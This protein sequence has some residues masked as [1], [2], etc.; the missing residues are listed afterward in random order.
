MFSTGNN[1]YAS[2]LRIVTME[3]VII[4][5]KNLRKLRLYKGISQQ[6]L[7]DILGM[8]QQSIHQ[9][10]NHATEPDFNT[11][12]QLA[13]F[14]GTTTDFLIGYTPQTANPNQAEE[15][16]FSKEE[17]LLVRNYRRLSKQERESIQ[18]IID[19]YLNGSHPREQ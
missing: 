14:F 18:L 10:E 7:A 4:M 3:W 8:S 16:D 5:I 1:S 19:N 6:Q 2:L 11:L 13:G 17:F 12:M 15:L 9:Y